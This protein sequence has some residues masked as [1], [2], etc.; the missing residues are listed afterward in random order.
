MSCSSEYVRTDRHKELVETCVFV[1]NFLDGRELDLNEWR[2]IV[3]GSVL[4]LQGACVCAICGRDTSHTAVLRDK[5]RTEWLQYLGQRDKGAEP[6]KNQKIAGLVE[7]L[8][9]AA[10]PNILPSPHTLCETSELLEIV[11]K[12]I[13]IRNQFVHFSPMSW[14]IEVKYVAPMIRPVWRCIKK[15][16]VEAPTFNHHIEPEDQETLRLA[17]DQ[18]LGHAV[19]RNHSGGIA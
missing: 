11:K 7:L 14:S 15:L 4:A 12:L 16:V 8:E 9:R 10:D 18:V 2:W 13:S 5:N 1:S 3:I 6:P 17:V 19:L